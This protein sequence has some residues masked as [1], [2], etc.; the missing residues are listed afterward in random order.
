M[1]ASAIVA[2]VPASSTQLQIAT[3]APPAAQH[4]WLH[5]PDTVLGAADGDCL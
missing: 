2:P 4:P 5:Q 1:T 3:H